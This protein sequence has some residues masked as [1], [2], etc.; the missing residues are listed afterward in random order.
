MHAV[1]SF[2]L[3]VLPLSVAPFE[4]FGSP[5]A[6]K[7]SEKGSP[8][9]LSKAGRG[10]NVCYHLSSLLCVNTAGVT[11][12]TPRHL[13]PCHLYIVPS[14]SHTLKCDQAGAHTRGSA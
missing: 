4:V 12:L 14:C 6:F 13:T 5:V 1:F 11:V 9:V 3:S 10:I 2:S 8:T 7:G